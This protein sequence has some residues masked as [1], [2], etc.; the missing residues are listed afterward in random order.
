MLYLDKAILLLVFFFFLMTKRSKYSLPSCR[1]RPFRYSDCHATPVISR[2]KANV[3]SVWPQNENLDHGN[4]SRALGRMSSNLG[5]FDTHLW[6]LV[7]SENIW[8]NLYNT[9]TLLSNS[10]ILQYNALFHWSSLHFYHVI[11][12]SW[13]KTIFRAEQKPNFCQAYKA[14]L[15]QLSRTIWKTK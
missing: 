14:G 5:C 4:M 10:E 12:Q 13:L 7:G 2:P 11:R 6:P 1:C 15:N 9:K 3:L 8:R